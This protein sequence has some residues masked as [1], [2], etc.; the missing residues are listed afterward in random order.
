M[1]ESGLRTKST[2]RSSDGT[3]YVNFS[4]GLITPFNE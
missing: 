3:F 4:I 2:I 1:F